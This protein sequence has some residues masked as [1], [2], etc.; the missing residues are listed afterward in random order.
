[1]VRETW[2][3]GLME[4]LARR[5]PFYAMP[6]AEVKSARSHGGQIL[7]SAQTI[8]RGALSVLPRPLS[9]ERKIRSQLRPYFRKPV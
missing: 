4:E 5:V 6:F 1:M 3:G 7:S 9:V 2:G 8:H